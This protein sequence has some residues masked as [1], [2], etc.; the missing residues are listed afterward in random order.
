MN[1]AHLVEI[2][3]KMIEYL[4]V[5]SD[6]PRETIKNSLIQLRNYLNELINSFEKWPD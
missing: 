4:F 1:H 6:A 5:E 3:E 2:T